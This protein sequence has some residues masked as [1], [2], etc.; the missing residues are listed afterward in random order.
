MDNMKKAFCMTMAAVTAAA[1]LTGCGNL[2]LNGGKK[3][4]GEKLTYWMTL[5]SNIKSQ[6][7]GFEETPYAKKLMEETGVEIEYV[8]QESD[9]Q[10]NLMIASN[11]LPDIIEHIW[12]DFPG[13]PE[14][15]IKDKIIIPLNDYIK[16]KAPNLAKYYKDHPEI[17]K[18]AMT[19]SGNQYMFPF[20]RGDEK[21]LTSAGPIVRRD[22]LDELGIKEP[23]TIDDWYNMLTE[24]K[25][26]K[27]AETPLTI[28]GYQGVF[29]F[30]FLSGAYGT[31]KTFFV[32]NGKVK[33]GPIEDG[34]KE[35]LIEMNKWYR[36]G[37]LDNNF[38]GIDNKIVDSSILNG[39]A[40]ATFGSLGSGIGKWLSAATEKGYDLTGVKYPVLKKGDRAFYSS[41]QNTVPGAG[42]TISTSCKKLDEA[43]KVL[44][45]AYSEKGKML[46]NFGVEGE[47][48]E[49]KNGYPTYTKHITENSDGT[50][51]ANILSLYARAT[52]QGP[53]VQDVRYIVQYASR[54][55]QQEALKAWIDTDCGKHLLPLVTPT[56]EESSELGKL[57]N[58]CTTYEDESMIGF[59]T[60]KTS[61][62]KWDEYVSQMKTLGIDR[63]IEINQKAYDRYQSR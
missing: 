36:E 14:K 26:R 62:D 16:D 38:V 11:E 23:E 4:S 34:Y 31:P 44:D 9:E 10:F 53:F 51:M 15:A 32:D 55:Q 37:L 24:F 57:I 43:F 12:K 35:F 17:E 27:G 29:A 13:G 18:S 30:G 5:D 58:E 8:Y 48:Y 6:V 22:W 52:G 45:F 46:N 21:L 1:A 50:P 41:M 2:G 56:S 33:Y 39:K 49:M 19:D 7:S 60:G 63:A 3:K 28:F 42:A 59:I 54:P 47:S 20:V 61:F 40:G 25:T